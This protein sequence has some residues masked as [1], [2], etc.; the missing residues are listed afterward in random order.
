MPKYFVIVWTVVFST[1][2]FNVI[3][4]GAAANAPICVERSADRTAKGDGSAEETQ[5]AQ[6]Q[7]MARP[8]VG[9]Y[10]LSA[11]AKE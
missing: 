2:L 4:L 10:R 11:W 5:S 8:H 3:P 6:A 7:M 9:G 1:T